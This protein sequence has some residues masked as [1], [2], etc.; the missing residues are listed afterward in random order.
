MSEAADSPS[1]WT[2]SQNTVHE[3]D[4]PAIARALSDPQLLRLAHA[5]HSTGVE[6]DWDEDVEDLHPGMHRLIDAKFASE[7][8]NDWGKAFHLTDTGRQAFGLQARKNHWARLL[9]LIARKRAI[10]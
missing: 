9:D 3:A 6:V 7:T 2:A 1:F 8:R 5:I 4:A 10:P